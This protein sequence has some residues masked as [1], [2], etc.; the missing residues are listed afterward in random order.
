MDSFYHRL[1][2]YIYLL[3]KTESQKI[4]DY[5]G[6]SENS[7]S[8]FTRW[9]SYFQ[10]ELFIDII[11]VSLKNKSLRVQI[12]N[13]IQKQALEG[14][15]TAAKVIL[16]EIPPESNGDTSQGLGLDDALRIINEAIKNEKKAS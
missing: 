8:T 2:F 10:K 11:S 3:N 7:A 1:K 4:S 6:Y 5:E 12:F 16:N 14:N 13:A 9:K 15:V